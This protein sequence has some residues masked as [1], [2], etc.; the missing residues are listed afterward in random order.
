MRSRFHRLR[1]HPAEHHFPAGDAP[2]LLSGPRFLPRLGPEL[3]SDWDKFSNGEMHELG[4]RRDLAVAVQRVSLQLGEHE[5]LYKTSPARGYKITS[6]NHKLPVC[7]AA[8]RCQEIQ[9]ML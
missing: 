9:A 6:R 3:G 8:R 4:N 7:Q 5:S 1:A 2:P